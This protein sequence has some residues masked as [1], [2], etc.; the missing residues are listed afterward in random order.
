MPISTLKE[1]SVPAHDRFLDTSG[2]VCPLPVLKARKELLALEKG[3]ILLLY[4]T[5]LDAP[6][7]LKGLCRKL[8][9]EIICEQI[10]SSAEE[11]S[12]M[13]IRA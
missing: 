6:N 4:M 1:T 10:S 11:P 9:A 12:R 8:K 7:D 3:K 13:W 2:L 5:D